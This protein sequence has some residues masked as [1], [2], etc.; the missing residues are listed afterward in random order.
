MKN[1]SMSN[2]TWIAGLVTAIAASL[3]CITPV[4]A[5]LGGL[6]GIA[7]SFSWLESLRPY[8][9]GFTVLIFGISWYQKLKPKNSDIECD[10]EKKQ[11]FWQSKTFLTIITIIAGLL[12]TFPYY[13]HI[14]Y[15]KPQQS[16]VIIVD[17]NNI[18]QVKL[19]V[20]GMTCR[21]C[22]EHISDALSKVNGVIENKTSYKEGITIVKFDRSVTDIDSIVN[23][24]NRTGYTVKEKTI[25]QN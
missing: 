13:A 4:L 8:L 3:C 16:K 6:G 18:E 1:K 25:I 14:F 2:K 19:G 22:E 17:K 21:G 5:L 11:S 7:S 20:E 23:A 15:S 9:L 10:C 24:V 12:V